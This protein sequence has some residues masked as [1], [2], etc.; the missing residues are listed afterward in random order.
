MI[1]ED[2]T[3]FEREHFSITCEVLLLKACLFLVVWIIGVAP[4]IHKCRSVFC[5]RSRK[6][7]RSEAKF[8]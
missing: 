6:V 8:T 7:E 2:V 3:R 1:P 5:L 4:L